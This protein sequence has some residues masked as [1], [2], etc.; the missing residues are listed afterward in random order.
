MLTFK[1]SN[2]TELSEFKS[3]TPPSI[4]VASL[5]MQIIFYANTSIFPLYMHV[6]YY[7]N[8]HSFLFTNFYVSCFITCAFFLQ[9]I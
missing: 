8:T 7:I 4:V 9:K 2:I 6:S 1:G 5:I 3:E